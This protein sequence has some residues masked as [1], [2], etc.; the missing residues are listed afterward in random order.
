MQRRTLLF[1]FVDGVVQKADS[2]WNRHGLRD[3]IWS[4]GSI[5]VDFVDGSGDVIGEAGLSSVRVQ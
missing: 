4:H 1:A 5:D 3:G 2:F